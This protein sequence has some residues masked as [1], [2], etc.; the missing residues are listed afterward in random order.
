MLKSTKECS[1]RWQNALKSATECSQIGNNGLSAMECSQIDDGL[2]ISD[3]MLSNQ[4]RFAYQ[5]R[6]ALKSATVGLLFGIGDGF[7]SAT[8]GFLT[9]LSATI[10]FG[11]G[12]VSYTF[13]SDSG[14]SAMVSLSNG[15]VSH[16]FIGDGW[17]IVDGGFRR[18]G[19]RR[20]RRLGVSAS[21]F[22]LLGVK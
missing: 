3:G 4:W 9:C 5:R 12:G 13:I 8:V 6:N 16:T 11:N 21:R 22:R 1:N 19:V 14:L 17:S 18:L 20:W 10:W 15:G 7:L 2:L